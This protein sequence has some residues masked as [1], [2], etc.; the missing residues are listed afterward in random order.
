MGSCT[1]KQTEFFKDLTIKKN[2][3][4]E[5]ITALCGLVTRDVTHGVALNI[6]FGIQKPTSCFLCC[7]W[8][9][10]FGGKEP[11]TMTEAWLLGTPLI[12]TEKNDFLT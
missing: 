6:L 4:Q 3:Q 9:N 2:T 7:G 5:L 11:F 8:N 1:E 10:D 12:F